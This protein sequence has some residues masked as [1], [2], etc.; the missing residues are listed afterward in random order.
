[1]TDLGVTITST[2]S[3]PRTTAT[4]TTSFP[5]FLDGAAFEAY[6]TGGGRRRFAYRHALEPPVISVSVAGTSTILIPSTAR[7]ATTGSAGFLER[8]TH[9]ASH[10][11]TRGDGLRHRTVLRADWR[12][13][14]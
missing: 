2:I 4:A 9:W 8:A 14:Y 3:E 11:V 12:A 10:P 6:R 5:R 13:D 1:V 7:S